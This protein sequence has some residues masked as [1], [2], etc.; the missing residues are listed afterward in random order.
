MGHCPHERGRA[1]RLHGK[2]DSDPTNEAAYR[3]NG[4]QDTLCLS[5]GLV[6]DN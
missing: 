1:K 4:E 5:P 2:A 6:V 3:S